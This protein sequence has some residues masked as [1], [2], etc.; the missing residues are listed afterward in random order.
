MRRVLTFL[1]ASL[2]AVPLSGCA[3]R[4]LRHDQ[5]KI[6]CALLDLYTNQIMDN[7]VRASNGMPII[8]IDYTNA[9]GTITAKE[10]AGLSETTA[11]T[12][13]NVF[14]AAAARSL[15]VTRTIL[16]TALGTAGVEH[17]NQ[18]A[19]TGTPVTTANEVYDAYLEFLSLPG[20]LQVTCDPPP[21]GAAHICK[22]CDKKYYWVPAEFKYQFLR[23]SL[24][25][26]AQRGKSLLAP[27]EFYS[28]TLQKIVSQEE[29]KTKK[30]VFV[31]NDTGR[32]E[33]TEGNKTIALE[34]AEFDD[35]NP[36]RVSD[37]D[38][39][40]VFFDPEVTGKKTPADLKLP[41]GARIYLRHNRPTPPT[42]SDL[43]NRVEFQ[44]QQIQFNQ[45]RTGGGP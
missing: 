15:V 41:L 17:T 40:V 7:L 30:G 26:T 1:V 32:L 23:L 21:E 18:V 5:D 29:S 31:P 44:L 25:T 9:T 24:L 22:Q 3:V 33:Y 4:E 16:G 12:S 19:V 45:L 38:Q 42:T 28:V 10:T 35:D 13:S 11:T 2:C 6:R 36:K 37:T 14:T 8:Q 27:D 20:S 43:L 34:V 39:I